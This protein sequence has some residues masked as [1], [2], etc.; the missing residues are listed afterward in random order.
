MHQEQIRQHSAGIDYTAVVQPKKWSFLSFVATMARLLGRKNGTSSFTTSEF[1]AL[2]QIY[3]RCSDLNEAILCEAFENAEYH[4]IVNI[5]YH[6][7]QI[8]K[9]E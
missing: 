6:L 7:Q 9:G 3:C 5:A 4:D 1:E 2:N 8:Q